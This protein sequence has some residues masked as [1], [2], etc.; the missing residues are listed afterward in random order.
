M[1]QCVSK[2]NV[3]TEWEIVVARLGYDYKAMWHNMG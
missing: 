3:V 2:V 1:Q